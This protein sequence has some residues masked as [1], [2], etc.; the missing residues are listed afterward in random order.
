MI[1]RLLVALAL[2]AVVIGFMAVPQAAAQQSVNVYLGGFTPHGEDSRGNSDVLFQDKTFMLFNLGD[3]NGVTAGGE[4][5]V[6]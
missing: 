6:G 3:L 5:L 2:V 1:R 4:W